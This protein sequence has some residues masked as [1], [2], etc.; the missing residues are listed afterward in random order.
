M[1]YYTL[2]YDKQTNEVLHATW[3]DRLYFS[4]E[5]SE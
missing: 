2:V 4:Y 3:I 5:I 1:I